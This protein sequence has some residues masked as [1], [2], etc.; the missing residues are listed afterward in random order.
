M[1]E[2]RPLWLPSE[3]RIN[4]SNL[5]KFEDLVYQTEGLLFDS[6][7][8]MHKWSVNKPD[9]FWKLIWDFAEVRCSKYFNQVV[10]NQN[11]FSGARWFEGSRLNFAENLLRNRSE[12]T[13]IVS[14]LENGERV[15]L[16]YKELFIKVA[17]CAHGLRALGLKKDDRVA[18]FVT[19]SVEAVIAM[20]ATT[21][22]GAIWSSCSPDF[23]VNGVLDRFGQIKPKVLFACKDYFYN[24]KHIDCLPRLKKIQ[25]NISSLES[26]IVFSPL[27]T[28]KANSLNLEKTTSFD[29]VCENSEVSID[30]EQLPFNHPLYIMY[31]SGTTGVPKCIVHCAGGALLQH[32]KEHRLHTNIKPNDVVFYF[33]TCG[34]MMWNWLVSVLA[35][36]ATIL[37]Y[38]GSPFHPKST[39][40]LDI[41]D[42][43]KVSIF[44]VSAKYISAIEKSGLKPIH[45][46]KLD[47]M[48][49]I[50]ST[51]SPLTHGGFEYVY[52]SFSPDIQLSSI[53]G[54]T[55]IL[56]A[57]VAGNPYMPVCSGEI[58]CK[59]LGMDVQIWS[60]MGDSIIEEKG[61]LVCVNP[62]PSAPIYFWNDP[63]DKKYHKAYFEKFDNVWCQGDYGEITSNEGIVIYGRSDA[64]LNPGGVRIGTAEIYRQVEKFDQIVEAVCVGQL[65]EDDTR[66]ILFVV[67]RAGE[68][69]DDNLIAEIKTLIRSEA[70]PRHVPAKIIQVKDI[71]RTISGKVVEI[72]VRSLIH[73]E[74]I[75]NSDALANPESLDYFKELGQ[76][77]F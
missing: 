18:G 62:F 63:G 61:E 31:S 67:V 55:D 43:E 9:Q 41:A 3:Q 76:L 64:T 65:W 13:A 50:L 10:L 56:S 66:V 53:S 8:G 52:K 4:E 20:L 26:T 36:E 39:A 7:G 40:L 29:L 73:G 1:S 30:F 59:T 22:I 47:K 19:N 42:Q 16:S 57:F 12:K 51:G 46:H 58:Q 25:N 35:S 69:L 2:S 17:K 70:T 24:G 23:G 71:P 37:L 33:S 32:L 48:H 27:N 77:K 11:Q 74:D 28:L 54:G 38:D 15:A 5:K 75:K 21:S 44:G 60:D 34:W 68:Y 72:A 45:S 6:Y 49:T 14:I